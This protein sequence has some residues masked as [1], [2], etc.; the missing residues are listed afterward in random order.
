MLWMPDNKPA[1]ADA[2]WA[3]IPRDVV[4]STG[5]CQ[6]VLDGGSLVHRIPWQ[7]GTTYNDIC[8]QQSTSPENMDMPLL[9]STGT[10]KDYP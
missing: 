9:S 6:Y 4:G 7:R 1:L 2:V 5:Q 10:R 8:M 3:L